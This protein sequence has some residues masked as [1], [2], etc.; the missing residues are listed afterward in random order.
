MIRRKTRLHRQARKTGNWSNFRQGQKECKKAFRQ[1]EWTYINDVIQKGL[2][3][4]NT[5]PFWRYVKSKKQDSIGVSPLRSRGQ[6]QSDG[7]SKA[8]VLVNQTKA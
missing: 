7:K 4:N 2:D 5:K 3:S 6:L 8:E 1:A